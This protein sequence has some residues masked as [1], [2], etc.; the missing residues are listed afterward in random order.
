MVLNMC[1]YNFKKITSENIN[2]Q[3]IKNLQAI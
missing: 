2:N 1:K 3:L